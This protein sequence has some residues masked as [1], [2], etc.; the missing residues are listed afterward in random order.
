MKM[1]EPLILGAVNVGSR[2]LVGLVEVV[3]YI[4]VWEVFGDKMLS[5]GI[6]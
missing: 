3:V 2:A 1:E 4:T 6:G 5:L